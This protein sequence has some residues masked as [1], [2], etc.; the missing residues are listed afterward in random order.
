MGGRGKALS[1]MARQ[2]LG[3][4][5]QGRRQGHH[6]LVYQE[7]GKLTGTAKVDMPQ[8]PPSCVLGCEGD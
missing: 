6:D 2:G 4:Q 1:L 7:F 5:L 8:D 3:G